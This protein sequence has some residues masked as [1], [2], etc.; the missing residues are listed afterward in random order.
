IAGVDKSQISQQRLHL[1]WRGVAC[2]RDNKVRA[3][4]A[5]GKS[6]DDFVTNLDVFVTK[7]DPAS[8]PDLI[9]CQQAGNDQR[10]SAE[11][12]TGGDRSI[13]RQQ[14]GDSALDV[15]RRAVQA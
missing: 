7:A 9:L 1:R 4:G 5:T 10:L 2:K 15:G 8:K 11:I 3:V 14:L 6:P 13:G 12:S